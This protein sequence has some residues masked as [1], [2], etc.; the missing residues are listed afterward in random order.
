MQ[1][2]THGSERPAET[3]THLSPDGFE[4]GHV[5]TN[6]I[7]TYYERY[8]D[9]PAVVFVHGMFMSSTAWRPQTV[10]LGDEYTTI[11]Y[12]VRG[13]GHTGGS[14]ADTYSID[15]YAEDLHA[16]LAVL[17]VE[18]PVLCGLSMGGAIAQMYAATHPEN[19]AG[20]VLS[21]TFTAAPLPA[22]SRLFFQNL[23]FLGRLDRFVRYPT[24]NRIQLWVGNRLSPG[25]GG[26]EVTTQRLIEEAPT[27]SHAE[28]VKI[29]DSVAAF[30]EGDLDASRITVPTLVLHGEHVPAAF[31]EMHVRLADHL[32]NADVET[33]VVPDAGHASNVDTPTFFTETVREFLSTVYD[34]PGSTDPGDS[35]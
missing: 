29:A 1:D 25:V 30:P 34:E 10:A 23:R 3:T 26:D 4:T 15:L 16:L 33:V 32:A 2:A 31:R 27:I 7:E 18:R 13:H 24:L 28:I 11:A 12:D 14:D 8:G 17:D 21:D 35:A 19:V 5:E 22:K 6:G 9:G 20:L